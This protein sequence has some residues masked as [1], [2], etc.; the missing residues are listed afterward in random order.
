M[1]LKT[2]LSWHDIEK[3]VNNIAVQ[4]YK[5]NWKPDYI[6]GITSGGNIPATMLSKML[7]ITLYSLDVRLRDGDGSGPE[8]NCWMS[9]DAYN[10]K[11]I[12]IIDDIN[13]SGATLNWIKDDWIASSLPHDPKWNDIWG[14]D[15]RVAVMINN[16]SSSSDVNYF[17]K[18]I[19]KAEKNEWIVFPWE[20]FWKQ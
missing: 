4:L 17:A 8:S 12:L 16:V 11:K 18:E 2:Y 7:G 9:E 6:V 1:T 10:G 20:E 5:D 15:V 3:H 13:D 19:N 14:N